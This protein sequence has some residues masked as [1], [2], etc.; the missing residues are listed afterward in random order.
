MSAKKKQEWNIGDLFFVKLTDGTYAM[1]QVLDTSIPNTASCAFFDHRQKTAIPTNC[2]EVTE[3][4]VIATAT[5]IASHLDRGAWSVFTRCKPVLAREKWPNEATRRGGWV[6][7][8]V[9]SGAILEDF[10]N[11]YYCLVPWDQFHDPQYL[12][13]LLISPSK[14]PKD[15]MYKVARS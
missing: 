3:D 8:M 12:D 9:Y 2:V 6:G 14:K 15:L 7:S 13:R 10:F 5:V 11:A 4:N 1:G